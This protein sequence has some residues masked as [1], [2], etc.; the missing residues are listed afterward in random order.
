MYD[1]QRIQAVRRLLFDY[2]QSPSLRHLR[3]QRSVDGLAERIIQTVDREPTVW[4]SGR[5]SG[6]LCYARPP[7]AGF[8]RMTSV[9]S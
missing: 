2:V 1:Y 9:N 4:R 3:D 5:V 8:Q 6:K 7:N